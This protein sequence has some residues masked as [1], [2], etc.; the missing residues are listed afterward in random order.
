MSMKHKRE[1]RIAA[2]LV[3][4]MLSCPVMTSWGTKNEYQR[5]Q[6]EGFQRLAM[7]MATVFAKSTMKGGPIEEVAEVLRMGSDVY[8]AGKHP[9]NERDLTYGAFAS[10]IATISQILE[11][12]DQPPI[13]LPKTRDT[14]DGLAP[15]YGG[16]SA[17][18]HGQRDW[19]DYLKNLV[20]KEDTEATAVW[21]K[22]AETLF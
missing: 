16:L 11:D 6:R 3:S 1:A 5:G 19:S 17:V 20:S 4:A 18:L 14:N 12:Y 21:L 22:E 8:R 9:G 2:S 13:S 7:G 10:L 15:S